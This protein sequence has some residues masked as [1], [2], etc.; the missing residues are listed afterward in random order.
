MVKYGQAEAKPSGVHQGR[1]GEQEAAGRTDELEPVLWGPSQ[2]PPPLQ[3]SRCCE[4]RVLVLW[5]WV[6]TLLLGKE[7]FDL[8]QVVLPLVLFSSPTD[9]RV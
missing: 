9:W 3:D 7:W 1:V 4:L 2:P 6:P 8:G 5:G